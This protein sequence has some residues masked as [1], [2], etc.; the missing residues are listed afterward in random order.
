MKIV[1]QALLALATE[2]P[3]AA[4]AALNAAFDAEPADIESSTVRGEGLDDYAEDLA[5]AGPDG[6]TLA[7]TSFETV[8]IDF[9]HDPVMRTGYADGSVMI[10][11]PD[12]RF[13]VLS[14]AKGEGA[15]HA[16]YDLEATPAE[17][18]A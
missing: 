2:R 12:E 13:A 11:V 1:I 10:S 17:K 14:R 9:Y 6:T 16:A 15:I 4:F 8:Q 7:P 3:A 5:I 18:R